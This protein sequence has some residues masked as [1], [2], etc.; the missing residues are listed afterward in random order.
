M[1][2][3]LI[4]IGCTLVLFAVS[5]AITNGLFWLICLCFG[6]DYTI[7]IGTGVWLVMVFVRWGFS[8]ARNL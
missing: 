7:L 5:W 2:D 6:W 8:S 1:L 3:R 4:V